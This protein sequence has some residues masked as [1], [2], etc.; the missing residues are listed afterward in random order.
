M[1]TCLRS[2]HS[3]CAIFPKP[4]TLHSG[5]QLLLQVGPRS[6]ISSNREIPPIK[7]HHIE[8]VEDLGEYRPRG[9]HP[10]LIEDLL[11]D[12]YK[13]IHKL[14]HGAYSTVWLAHDARSS[15][16]VAITVGSADSASRD[17]TFFADLTSKMA[18]R[19][20]RPTLM[21]L[22]KDRFT[23]QGP[24]GTHHCSITEPARCSLAASAF[25][26]LFHLDVARAL[27]A[28][29]ILRCRCPFPPICGL[30]LVPYGLY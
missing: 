17:A 23:I 25:T 11:Q 13:V 1:R 5:Q 20:G 12:R 6:S 10:V 14:G 27:I 9:Y 24:N 15:A 29:L 16:Y 30:W 18:K 26:K 21:A 22:L 28:Q 3:R 4:F 2:P 7:Y 19:P 8:G